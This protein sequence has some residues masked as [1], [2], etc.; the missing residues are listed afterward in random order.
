[1]ECLICCQLL[2][3]RQKKY[4]SRICRSRGYHKN[5]PQYQH[6][7]AWNRK[8]FI[9]QRLGG[10]CIV[11]GYNKNLSALAF[12]HKNPEFKSFNLDF[13]KISGSTMKKILNEVAKCELLC[14]NC[15][16]ELHNPDLEMYKLKKVLPKHISL[17][18]LNTCRCCGDFITE[19][20]KILF[21]EK[22]SKFRQR[23]TKYPPINELIQMVKVSSYVAVGKKLGVTDN[24]IRKHLRVRGIKLVIEKS[25][26]L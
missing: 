3:G 21:C 13:R 9:I 12:H 19:N 15:H 10:K 7:R 25:C 18:I 14:H 8:L 5:R 6:N 16:S 1:M 22:C 4:C 24:A 20:K 17:K 26:S 23:K 11:C 2:K